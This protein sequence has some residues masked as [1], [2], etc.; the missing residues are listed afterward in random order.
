MMG[1]DRT[2][3]HLATSATPRTGLRNLPFSAIARTRWGP[4][5]GSA[6]DLGFCRGAGDGNRTRTISLGICTVRAGYAA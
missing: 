6:A 2:G 1:E 4:T 5:P 3:Q